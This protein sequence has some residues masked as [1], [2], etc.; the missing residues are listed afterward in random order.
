MKSSIR[1]FLTAGA[2]TVLALSIWSG[3][4][5]AKDSGKGEGPIFNN[6]FL[7]Q[8]LG[9]HHNSAQI[10]AETPGVTETPRLNDDND[11]QEGQNATPEAAETPQVGKDDQGQDATPEATDVSQ[12]DSNG[13]ATG[14]ITAI[15]S[16][17][18]TIDGVV[19]N[20]TGSSEI[21]GSLQVGS[22]VKVEFVTNADGSLSVTEVKPGDQ[23]GNPDGPDQSGSNSSG[24]SNNGSDG[25]SHSG[26]EGDGGSGGG[27]SGSG[28]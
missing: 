28:G 1:I 7:S 13:E 25:E 14:T 21:S 6:A 17:T 11:G 10:S 27:G 3:V 24:D 26:S 16:S 12:P 9:S 22:T 18:V 19:Y 20:L 5:A 23:N 2:A 15:D 8:V 4:R